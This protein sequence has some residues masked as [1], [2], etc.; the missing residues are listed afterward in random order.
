MVKEL[1]GEAAS[2]VWLGFPSDARVLIVNCDDLGM[3]DRVNAGILTAV[4]QG[5]AT[6]CSLMVP[7]T[8]A[9]A[10]LEALRR[11]PD[12]PFGLHLTLTRDVPQLNWAPLASLESVTSLVDGDGLLPTS[13]A[14][15]ALLARARI[16][17][18]ELELRAQIDNVVV[19]GLRP[20][21]LDWHVLADGGRPDILD[22]TIA[23]AG[24]YGL[25]ARVWLDTGRQ[26]ARSLGLPCIDSAFLD[27]FSLEVPD[28]AQH[29]ERLL[30]ELPTGL[31]EWA[32]H[33]AAELSMTR[34]GLSGDST[35]DVDLG[36]AVRRSDL[37]FLTSERA[38]Q[39]VDEEGI[40]LIDYSPLQLA[41]TR[42]LRRQHAL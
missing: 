8:A 25:A 10:A 30:R 20:T 28:K 1:P 42:Q 41:W 22:L 38:R 6:S 18:V 16:E 13:A 5:I 37:D 33:P 39:I 11:C 36:W 31:H 3:D 35:E 23:L 15:P 4:R 34:D 32:V 21:H 26:A 14:A 2:S 7:A 29:Y 12:V 17:E 9:A 27:S 24:E 40:H 19:A